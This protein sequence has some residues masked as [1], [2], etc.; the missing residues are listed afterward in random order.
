MIESV[1]ELA[2]LVAGLEFDT[3]PLFVEPEGVV[4]VAELVATPGFGIVLLVV[5]P[6]GLR[7]PGSLCM[8]P[9]WE[10]GRACCHS[11]GRGCGYRGWDV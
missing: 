11:L 7:Q 2:E 1:D 8:R 5:G 3:S 10:M 4:A 9:S 6:A